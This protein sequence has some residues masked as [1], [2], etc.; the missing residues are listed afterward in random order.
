MYRQHASSQEL[1]AFALDGDPLSSVIRQHLDCCPS[2]QRRVA[3]YQN[4]VG[5]LLPLMYRSRCPS[6]TTLSY[7]CL[8]GALPDH[9]RRPIAEHLVRCPLCARELAETRAFLQVC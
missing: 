5:R 6:A 8:P 7:Y 9:E 4:T 3:R 1:L 2:C